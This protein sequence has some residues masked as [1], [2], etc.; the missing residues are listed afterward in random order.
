LCAAYSNSKSKRYLRWLVFGSSTCCLYAF[1]ASILAALDLK[2]ELFA[3]RIPPQ[4]LFKLL[5]PADPPLAEVDLEVAGEFL[6]DQV[7]D[8]LDQARI[9]DALRLLFFRPE[10]DRV[11]D[12][13]V[14]VIHG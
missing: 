2:P 6:V 10:L 1:V 11:P 5:D 3:C 7:P 13:M 12:C 9:L 8:G 14:S 4:D